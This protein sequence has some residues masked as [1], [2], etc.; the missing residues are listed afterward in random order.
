MHL[1]RFHVAQH[2]SFDSTVREIKARAVVTEIDG[3][4]I[5][6][7]SA[8]PML[9]LCGR[10]FHRMGIAVRSQAVD[11]GPTGISKAEQL[12]D[13][14][15]GFAGGVVARVA[16]VLVGPGVLV[17]R[18]Q[19]KMRVA[20]GDYQCQHGEAKFAIAFL[21]LF[22]QDGMDVSF[23]M[24]DRDQRLLEREGQSFGVTDTDEK[25]SG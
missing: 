8:I 18:G 3:S 1:V 19:V 17:L 7:A 25:R 9:D 12:S 6:A 10:K 4:A 20:S 14:V 13:F 16:D 22:E 5:Q 21:A 2:R 11:D 24:I 15:E 23:E